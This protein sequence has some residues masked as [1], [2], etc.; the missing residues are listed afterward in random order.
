M[1][2]F[3]VITKKKWAETIHKFAFHTAAETYLSNYIILLYFYHVIRN[4]TSILDTDKY[5][6]SAPRSDSI[7][8]MENSVCTG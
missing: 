3:A 7:Q 1:L 4:I 2:I 5:F 6:L 8:Y